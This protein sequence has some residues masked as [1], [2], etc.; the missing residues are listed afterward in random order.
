[1]SAKLIDFF[2]S[3][4]RVGV[5][6]C[7][8]FALGFLILKVF[9]MHEEKFKKGLLNC[10]TTLDFKHSKGLESFALPV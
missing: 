9:C 3:W 5:T 6:L 1:M 10:D 7:K 2:A 8:L 4:F